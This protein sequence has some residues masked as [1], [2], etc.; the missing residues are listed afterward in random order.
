[1]FLEILTATCLGMFFGNGLQAP[2]HVTATKVADVL[3]F[4]DFD[5]PIQI[6]NGDPSTTSS[7][8]I[9]SNGQ[10]DSSPSSPT[11][12]QLFNGGYQG[13]GYMNVSAL[14]GAQDCIQKV[15]ILSTPSLE[16][17]AGG[18]VKII[19]WE[20]TD[21]GMTVLPEIFA[22]S[23]GPQ[24]ELVKTPATSTEVL[25]QV[26]A[27]VQY[28]IT[29]Q[30][31]SDIFRIS[32]TFTSDP[33]ANQCTGLSLDEFQIV[34]VCADEADTQITSP[35]P[36]NQPI[37]LSQGSTVTLTGKAVG[38]NAT[39]A[40]I[41][42]QVQIQGDPIANGEGTSFTYTFQD[43]GT[44]DVL[45]A[46]VSTCGV[47]D[48]TPDVRTYQISDCTLQLP[49]TIITS[50]PETGGVY[51]YD[52]DE[53]VVMTAGL[54]MPSQETITYEWELATSGGTVQNG[55]TGQQFTIRIAQPG[56]YVV[57]CTARNDCGGVT[58]MPARRDIVIVGNPDLDTIITSPA[59]DFITLVA[60]QSRQFSAMA[61]TGKTAETTFSWRRKLENANSV[62][63]SFQGPNPTISFPDPGFYTV[64]CA[65][66]QQGF[67][68]PTP[69]LI[70]VQAVDASVR[71]T[72]PEATNHRL[73]VSSGTRVD[74]QGMVSDPGGLIDRTDWVLQPGGQV[75]CSDTTSCSIT[76]PQKGSYSVIFGD[77][78]YKDIVYVDVD[79]Q[80]IVTAW[81]ED[82]HG[83]RTNEAATL[84]RFTLKGMVSG[85]LANDPQLKSRWLLNGITLTP[86]D[87][88]TPDYAATGLRFPGF[89]QAR[90]LVMHPAAETVEA[91]INFQVYDPAKAPDAEIISPVNDINIPP[92]KAVFFDSSY[93]NTRLS[94]RNAEWEI[95]GPDGTP[96]KTG[97][98]ATLGRVE[99]DQ[100]GVYTAS[101]FLFDDH[102]SYL[103]DM[104]TISVGNPIL[105][106]GSTIGF[107]DY[108]NQPLS[109]ENRYKVNVGRDGQ[110]LRL[111]TE[112][113]VPS[114]F[115]LLDD[116]DAVA[117]GPVDVEA[118]RAVIKVG[119]LAAGLYTIRLQ[120]QGV[121]KIGSFSIGVN[122]LNPA[123]Y[124]A[125]VTEDGSFN[126]NIGIV[127]PNG[128][129]ADVTIYGYDFMGNKLNTP[130]N[131]FQI[132]GHGSFKD[133]VSEMF[134]DNA[135]SLAWIRVD[136]THQLTGY[137]QTISVSR[138]QAFGVSAATYLERRVYVPHIA[139]DTGYWYTRANVVNGKD[140]SIAASLV[141]NDANLE[142]NNKNSF[143]QDSFD[144]LEKFP[145][146]IPE[147]SNYGSF[148]E[149]SGEDVL[150]G[151]EIFG[152]HTTNQM[153]G[154]GLAGPAADNPNFTTRPE[155]MYFT[156]IADPNQFWTALALVNL[157]QFEQTVGVIA[158]GAGGAQLAKGTLT[159]GA[160]EKLAKVFPDFF[161]LVTWTTGSA[162]TAAAAQWVEIETVNANVTGYELF[163]KQDNKLMAGIEAITDVKKSI[164]MPFV[165]GSGNYAHGISV[166]NITNNSAT[167]TFRLYDDVGSVLQT[168]TRNLLGKEKQIFQLEQL[169]NPLPM[170][171]SW[172]EV[173]ST[174]EVV[175]F[176]L[177]INHPNDN[178]HMSGLIAR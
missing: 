89:Y 76:F 69:A 144:F 66:S 160:N 78:T 14:N 153:V 108:G 56:A 143:S 39:G 163:G 99:F 175:G 18:Q 86:D 88:V 121:G 33:N 91:R 97:S 151:N 150:T 34:G 54:A 117:Y 154:L 80:L 83:E 63:A 100:L 67:K 16:W 135:S 130:L 178:E 12:S 42:W 162:A 174:Q 79:A 48:S 102:G 70:T 112:I 103:A 165:D 40:Q 31:S 15:K 147:E 158:Y 85:P 105:E 60:G 170:T 82:E 96:F 9:I 77:D 111:E 159:L 84:K 24:G 72:S 44:F 11:W 6:V 47:I 21:Q 57:T 2:D 114:Q 32:R 101:L 4:E 17:T 50:P 27:W 62:E 132:P 176:E 145:G 128:S 169:F 28:Q 161:P 168:Q 71:I 35:G 94:R 30:I 155:S 52:V 107:G 81:F 123:L 166:V 171:S 148:V 49:K 167:V 58:S 43:Q 53:Q 7:S 137:S 74:F 134:P 19:V 59:E 172:L 29:L 136:S 36:E 141:T 164:C 45:C 95:C 64:S 5:D 126:S 92:G 146:G 156:H 10:G 119:N 157:E 133:N 104:R 25:A 115:E 131:T 177:F 68:D 125:G 110:T 41:I 22:T 138:L 37:V 13:P 98:G 20:R 1:M 113:D 93:R 51:Y 142:L 75:V 109:E 139:K 106:Q 23:A 122:T 87:N 149:D 65:A 3:I 46:A 118:G 120:P 8:W 61:V 90:L 73:N 129:A 140:Q 38:P 173:S 124:M 127:N 116:Q 152:T 26:G 55:A